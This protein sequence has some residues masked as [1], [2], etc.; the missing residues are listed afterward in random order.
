MWNTTILNIIYY[1]GR[2][3]VSIK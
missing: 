1:A 3:L 2:I